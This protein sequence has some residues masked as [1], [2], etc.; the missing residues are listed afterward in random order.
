LTLRKQGRIV[1]HEVRT[2]SGRKTFL[3][4]ISSE[5]YKRIKE[6]A[7]R[8]Q[9]GLILVGS[10]VSG[11]RSHQRNYSKVLLECLPLSSHRRKNSATIQ[12]VDNVLIEKLK[13]KE[14]GKLNPQTSDLSIFI[15]NK[16]SFSEARISEIAKVI[17]EDLNGVIESFPVR[18]FPKANGETIES[19]QHY[20]RRGAQFLRQN[21]KS[22]KVFSD[23]DYLDAYRELYMTVNIREKVFYKSDLINALLNSAVLSFSFALTIGFHPVVA[24]AGLLMGLI[25]RYFSRAVGYISNNFTNPALSLLMG[26][27]FRSTIGFLLMAVLIN[28]MAGFGFTLLAIATYTITH[29]I[30]KGVIQ[31]ALSK[32]YYDKNIRKQSIGV[33]LGILV[34]FLTSLFTGLNYIGDNRGL[35]LQVFFVATGLV[36]IYLDYRKNHQTPL[37]PA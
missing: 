6:L 7:Q 30:T 8:Y 23:R 12:G 35:I 9:V 19:E 25:G 29:S 18:V 2:A 10:R 31:V 11:P 32:T 33:F 13:I 1:N 27:S 20:L 37:T 36:M 14:F 16:N 24:I 17:E 21:N 26:L 4:G 15:V 5:Q 3:I 28:P 34:N 22:D